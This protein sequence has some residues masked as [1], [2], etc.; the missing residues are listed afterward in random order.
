MKLKLLFS[1]VILLS[2]ADAHSQPGYKQNFSDLATIAFPDTPKTTNNS[3][4]ITYKTTSDSNSYIVLVI[5][6]QGKTTLSSAADLDTFYQGVIEGT[7]N[8]AK[9]TE[10]IYRKNI[11]LEGQKALEFEYSFRA[12]P[13][14]TAFVYQRCVFFNNKAFAIMFAT[15][16]NKQTNNITLKDKFLNSFSITADKKT[17]RQFSNTSNLAYILG[18]ALGKFFAYALIIGMLLLIVTLIRKKTMKTVS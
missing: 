8:P 15:F 18:H 4:T 11:L 3:G 12:D 7:V 5:D 2:C 16:N 10:I 9:H 13:S 17:T 6:L 14:K 1:F